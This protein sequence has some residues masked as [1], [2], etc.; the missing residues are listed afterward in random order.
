MKKS[1]IID[2]EN[3]E[4]SEKN[5]RLTIWYIQIRPMCDILCGSTETTPSKKSHL[6]C[7]YDNESTSSF[8]CL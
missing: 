4:D 3:Y 8:K 5:I 6:L 7:F 2:A 1:I